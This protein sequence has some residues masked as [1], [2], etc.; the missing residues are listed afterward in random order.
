MPA[1]E[2][3]DMVSIILPVYNEAGNLQPLHESL[4]NALD[5]LDRSTEVIFVDDGSSDAS[6]KEIESRIDSETTKR[7]RLIRLRRNYGQTTAFMAGIDQAKGGIIVLMDADRQNDPADIAK[8]LEHIEKGY[9]VVAG[10]R[11]ERNDPLLTKCLPSWLANRLISFLSGVPMHDYGCS[12]KAYRRE[13]ISGFRLYGEMHRFIPIYAHWQGAKITEVPVTHHPRTAGK[14]NYGLS[15]TF[16]VIMDLIVVIFLHEYQQKPMYVF[17]SAALVSM[18]VGGLSGGMA[19]YYKFFGD[20]SFIQ[21]PLPL[22]CVM[23]FLTAVM[24]FLMGLLAELL[25]RIYYESQD[26]RTYN[27][28]DASDSR[29]SRIGF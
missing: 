23:C 5:A 3:I 20:K 22:L 18:I 1:A 24:C 28:V 10:W 4:T 8:L 14:S 27:S 16:K 15:R 17:G 11:K 29:D 12:L 21:T 25:I 13:A 9:D 26:K 7:S 6:I 2:H 19:V